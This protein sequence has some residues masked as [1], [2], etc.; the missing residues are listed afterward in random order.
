MVSLNLAAFA[1]D[2]T[3]FLPVVDNFS[4]KA[5]PVPPSKV[6]IGSMQYPDTISGLGRLSKT[7]GSL[8]ACYSIQIVFGDNS[9]DLRYGTRLLKGDVI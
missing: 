4:K 1:W 2:M 9:N 5:F 7:A 6:C 8:R 3:P